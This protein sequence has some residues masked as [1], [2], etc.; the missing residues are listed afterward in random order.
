MDIV[1]DESS[2]APWDESSVAPHIWIQ[3]NKSIVGKTVV[4]CT[5]CNCEFESANINLAGSCYE[6]YP[7]Y[8]CCI[9]RDGTRNG[10]FT[11]KGTDGKM[12]KVHGGICNAKYMASDLSRATEE[13]KIMAKNYLKDKL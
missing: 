10:L 4:K 3:S 13:E 6:S 2:I 8:C 7:L 1:W 9:C 5:Q 11:A 12:R